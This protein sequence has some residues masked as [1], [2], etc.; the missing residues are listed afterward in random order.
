[1]AERWAVAQAAS[2]SVAEE[3]VHAEEAAALREENARLRE[4][5]AA[6]EAAASTRPEAEAALS[7]RRGSGELDR[8]KMDGPLEVVSQHTLKSHFDAVHAAREGLQTG[9]TAGNVRRVESWKIKAMHHMA[10]HQLEEAEQEA[11]RMNEKFVT[12]GDNFSFGFGGL[13]VRA[14][15]L[16]P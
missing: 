3:A 4:R 13:D 9:L 5:I 11:V 16:E 2:S 8:Y 10:E 15:H 1:M 7:E 14:C 12:S 6:L